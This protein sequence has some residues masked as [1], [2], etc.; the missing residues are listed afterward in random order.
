MPRLCN[1]GYCSPYVIT[2]NLVSGVS[3]ILRTR[4][5]RLISPAY[6]EMMETP[7]GAKQRGAVYALR[8]RHYSSSAADAIDAIVQSA[9]S[10]S[11]EVPLSSEWR[12]V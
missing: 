12:K 4:G 3:R 2:T 11:S 9:P 7:A 5:S 6:R 1:A 8:V 10:D